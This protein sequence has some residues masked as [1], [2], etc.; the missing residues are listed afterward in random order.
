MNI[1]LYI[2]VFILTYPYP[3]KFLEVV[4]SKVI[5]IIQNFVIINYRV[6]ILLLIWNSINKQSFIHVNYTFIE[7]V[8]ILL[9]HQLFYFCQVFF[10]FVV[11]SEPAGH[12]IHSEME[13]EF[14]KCVIHVAIEVITA[15]LFENQDFG[16]LCFQLFSMRLI[17]RFFNLIFYQV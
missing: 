2:E 11:T 14:A 17:K 3:T 9:F 4:N 1:I 16:I 13:N 7:L 10:N 8:V 15:Y 12:K 5:N 6:G